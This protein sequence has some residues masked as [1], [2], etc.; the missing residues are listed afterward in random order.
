MFAYEPPAKHAVKVAIEVQQTC[1]KHVKYITNIKYMGCLQ[2]LLCMHQHANFIT[3]GK[4]QTYNNEY[5]NG[6]RSRYYLD[7]PLTR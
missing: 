4:D 2:C 6:K 1:S 7:L 5:D 3:K